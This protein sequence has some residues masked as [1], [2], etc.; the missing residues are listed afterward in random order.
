AP[1]SVLH[2]IKAMADRG[3][4]VGTIPQDS[5]QLIHDL[6]D[7][8][9]YDQTLI[10]QDQY[11]QAL[12]KVSGKEYLNWF[13]QLPRQ[14]Q[15]KIVEQWGPPPGEAYIFNKQLIVAGIESGNLVFVLQPPRG[16]GMD[17][18]AIY[19]QPD[20]P[21]THHYCAMYQWLSKIWAADAIV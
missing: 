3:Y 1:A 15:D 5:N 7:R 18:N 12:G 9:S 6:I 14:L 4:N 16:Y 2:L 11:R 21:P 10:S 20:L 8:C 17:P 19:H 13:A